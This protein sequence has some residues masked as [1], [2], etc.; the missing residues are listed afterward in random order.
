MIGAKVTLEGGRLGGGG[1]EE[2][3]EGRKGWK[4]GKRMEERKRGRG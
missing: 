3:E 4:A 1:K 2:K